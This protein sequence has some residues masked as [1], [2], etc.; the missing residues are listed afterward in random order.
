MIEA[1]LDVSLQK[2]VESR[3]FASNFPQSRMATA[4][5]AEAVTGFVEVGPVWAVVNAFQ[6]E[7]NDLLH[8]FI[9]C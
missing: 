9:A 1:R 2:P 6:N 8:D 7:T 3:P 5:W 4:V